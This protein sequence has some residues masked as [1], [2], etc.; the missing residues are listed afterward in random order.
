MDN[1]GHPVASPFIAIT[2]VWFALSLVI[3]T[4]LGNIHPYCH[5]VPLLGYFPTF[6]V[7]SPVML[8]KGGKL[9]FTI[10]F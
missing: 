4:M 5:A 1:L 3:M 6:A 2:I 7:I 9:L 8:Y 10:L